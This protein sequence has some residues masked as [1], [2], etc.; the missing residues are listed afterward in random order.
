V[1]KR[2]NSCGSIVA[3]ER[4]KREREAVLGVRFS[5]EGKAGRLKV[6]EG[7]ELVV[8][9]DGMMAAGVQSE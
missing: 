4:L 3:V 5:G 7:G 2:L 9:E 8:G 6:V 1:L